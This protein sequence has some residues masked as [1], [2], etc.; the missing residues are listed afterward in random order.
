MSSRQKKAA[1]KTLAAG[2]LSENRG[3]ATPS[4]QTRAAELRERIEKTN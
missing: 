3:M 4:P 1:R 2:R